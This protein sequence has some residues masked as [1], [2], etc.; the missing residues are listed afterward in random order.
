MP[1]FI[2]RQEVRRLLDDGAQLVEV[3][4]RLGLRNAFRGERQR[5]GITPA[6][7]EGLRAVA[8]ADWLL[9]LALPTDDPFHETW[10]DNPAYR[11]FEVVRRDRV[12]PLGGDTWTWGGPLSAELAAKRIAD[13]V[14][15][16][17]RPY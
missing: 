12:V 17:T 1:G 11:R 7:L 8:D 5:W 2:D 16:E 9:T 13:A 10:A 6:G 15:G 4:R 14:T 3:L